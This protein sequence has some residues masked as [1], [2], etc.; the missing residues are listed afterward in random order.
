MNI[1]LDEGWD[2]IKKNGIDVILTEITSGS[3]KSN[4][5]F[6]HEQYVQV[7]TSVYNMATQNNPNGC[8]YLY[9]HNKDILTTYHNDVSLPMILKH[10][11]R[12]LLEAFIQR[13]DAAEILNKWSAKFFLY[14][15]RFY[16]INNNLPTVSKCVLEIFRT[17]VFKPVAYKITNAILDIIKLERNGEIV[18]T[19]IIG[20]CIKIFNNLEDYEELFEKE[21]LSTSRV[22]FKDCAS[23][24]LETNNLSSYLIHTEQV[25]DSEKTRIRNYL[26]VITIDKIIHIIV[27]EVLKLNASALLLKE[28]TGLKALLRNDRKEELAR[29]YRMFN[30][31]NE[32]LNI[33]AEIWHEYISEEGKAILVK[34]EQITEESTN[35]SWFV[36]ALLA[37][38]LRCRTFIY[39]QFQ[40]SP[41]FQKA[42]KIA[43][44]G[45][46]NAQLGKKSI[47]E[48][49]SAYTDSILKGGGDQ[50][51]S[52]TEMEDILDQIIH[53]FAFIT[54]KDIFVEIYRNYLAKRILNNKSTS[55]DAEKSMINKLK[56][57]CGAHFTSKLEGM[58]TD[59]MLGT[60]LPN[61]C[62]NLPIDF[63]IQVL[64]TGHWP[65]FKKVEVVLPENMSKCVDAFMTFYNSTSKSRVVNF[66]HSHGIIVLKSNYKI[67]YDISVA[68][69][70]ALVLLM[71]NEC[72][73]LTFGEIQTKYGG[74][75]EV[76]VAKKIMHSL[77][78]L[79]KFKLLEKYPESNKIEETDKFRVFSNFN[80]KLRK[81]RIP[82]A[83][84]EDTHN[85]ARVE[86]DRGHTIDASIVRIM[87]SRKTL[88][89]SVLVTEVIKQ[90]VLFKPEPKLIKKKI[91]SLIDREYLERDEKDASGNT[92]IYMA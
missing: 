54:D 5:L 32:E 61:E 29:I 18:D 69:L 53:L 71:F 72:E 77:S 84:M 34:R 2:D 21:F 89:H 56:L 92:Y 74:K 57:K 27:D 1:S 48:L 22:Y 35:E 91:E 49:L 52:E 90:L 65:T 43:F 42:F 17:T 85:I 73:W 15:D 47:T 16:V 9:N 40:S 36:Q 25:M 86:D 45:I 51:F 23:K 68:P 8:S 46:I 11:D 55:F 14:L 58:I 33:V 38:E 59:L 6:P 81:F 39:Q 78:C 88:T 12:F 50:K 82:M 70:Q 76:E 79:P 75:V 10:R 7:Y 64:T 30:I 41:L 28:E 24:W 62:K 63:G 67:S 80:S 60:T 3:F 37:L 20:K 87:K 4:I 26:D 13:W 66:I 83:S 44:E 31:Q 19:V